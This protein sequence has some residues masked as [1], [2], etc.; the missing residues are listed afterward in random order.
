MSGTDGVKHVQDAAA[1]EKEDE[2]EDTGVEVLRDSAPTDPSQPTSSRDHDQQS[3]SGDHDHD[4]DGVSVSES[5]RNGPE[6]TSLHSQ[7][8]SRK[9]MTGSNLTEFFS[10]ICV[11]CSALTV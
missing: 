5:K 8:A 11:R 6:D 1:D 4:A 10:R 7:V 2:V 9:D 3:G